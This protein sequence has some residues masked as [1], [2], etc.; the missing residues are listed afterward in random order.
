MFFALRVPH[1]GRR[2]GAP[3]RKTVFL[4]VEAAFSGGSTVEMAVERCMG[5]A[6][7][8]GPGVIGAETRLAARGCMLTVSLPSAGANRTWPSVLCPRVHPS[9]CSKCGGSG[10]GCRLSQTREAQPRSGKRKGRAARLCTTEAGR[11]RRGRQ[12]TAQ[13][14]QRRCST[15]A[16][17]APARWTESRRSRSRA[18]RRATQYGA[19]TPMCGRVLAVSGRLHLRAHNGPRFSSPRPSPRHP[20]SRALSQEHARVCHSACCSSARPPPVRGGWRFRDAH[21]NSWRS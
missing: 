9:L 8:S 2:S 1:P 3:L 7:Q 14:E 20:C 4:A 10:T 11:W 5:W 15:A 16:R 17:C 12:T 6:A 18:R 13:C 21:N 19:L